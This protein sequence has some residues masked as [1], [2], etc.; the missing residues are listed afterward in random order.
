MNRPGI[1]LIAV[2]IPTLFLVPTQ[3][4]VTI[5]RFDQHYELLPTGNVKAVWDI[6]IVPEDDIKSMLLHVFFSAKAYVNEVVVT[7][8]EGSLNAKMLSKE[9]VPILEIYF[10][11]RLTPGTEYH[12]TCNLDVWKA[13]DIGETEGSFTLLTGYNFPIEN[14][15]ITAVLPEGTRLRNY[16]PADGR[17]SLEG[18]TISWVMSSLPAGYNIQVSVSFDVLSESFADNLFHDGV[19]FYDLQDFDNARQKFEQALDIYESLELQERA[20]ECT[21]YLDRIDGLEEGLPLFKEAEDL[22]EEGNH[23]EAL[24]T[25]KEVKSIYE[26]HHVPTDEVDEYIS[27]GTTYMNAFS[28]LQKAESLLQEGKKEEAKTHYLKARQLFSDVGDNDM[29]EEI[30]SRIEQ[31][32]PEEKQPED[33]RRFPVFGIVVVIVIVIVILAVTKLR[34]PAP[35]YTAEE[36]REEMRQLKARFVYGEI[37]KKE[38]EEKLAELEGMLKKG[39]PEG[40]NE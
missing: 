2:V 14:L 3:E 5:L 15:D 31:I 32:P 37:N 21:L 9:G 6:T 19:E 33:G 28:A 4:K 10:R 7:D 23:A 27:L 18:D 39:K 29:V 8:S 38:Y 11:K 17:V 40:E 25:F 30:D 16:F 12:F 36:I 22:F 24:T 13:V 26:E 35:V 1:I 20:N 34:K